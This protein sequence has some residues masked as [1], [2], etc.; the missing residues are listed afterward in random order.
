MP[1]FPPSTPEGW[2]ELVVESIRGELT[3]AI[4]RKYV[5]RPDGYKILNGAEF[6][7][8]RI[9]S[10]IAKSTTSILSQDDQIDLAA[11]MAFLASCHSEATKVRKEAYDTLTRRAI[12]ATKA[13]PIGDLIKQLRDKLWEKEKSFKGNLLGTATRFF[14]GLNKALS[15]MPDRPKRWPVLDLKDDKS[16]KASVRNKFEKQKRKTIRRVAMRLRRMK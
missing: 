9:L 7:K 11:G 5:E 2:L 15:K 16:K 3:G 13:E 12:E 6:A 14:P 10:V 8:G 1:K 4:E